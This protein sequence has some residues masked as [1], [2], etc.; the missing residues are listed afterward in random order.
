MA[1]H[2]SST[3]T[4]QDTIHVVDS[5]VGTEAELTEK[6]QFS[7]VPSPS[8]LESDIHSA[9][10]S[11]MTTSTFAAS[12]DQPKRHESSSTAPT[13]NSN[14]IVKKHN[15]QRTLFQHNSSMVNTAG[16]ISSQ[17]GPKMFLFTYSTSIMDLPPCVGS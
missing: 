7:E 6:M 3:L 12:M 15:I 9:I 10:E 14:T 1:A 13:E 11:F 8:D 17:F 4:R 5:G 2:C 16:S